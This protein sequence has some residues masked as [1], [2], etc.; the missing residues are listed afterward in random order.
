MKPAE[1]LEALIL[2]IITLQNEINKLPVTKQG[3]ADSGRLENKQKALIKSYAKEN[4]IQ[5]YM[6]EKMMPLNSPFYRR[7]AE[8]KYDEWIKTK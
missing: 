8:N 2:S 6:K 3:L 7:Y 5:F 4:A 1:E